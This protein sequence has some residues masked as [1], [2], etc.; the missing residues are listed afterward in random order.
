MGAWGRSRGEGV[1]VVIIIVKIVGVW[2]DKENVGF[3]SV[4]RDDNVEDIVFFIGVN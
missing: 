3:M 4:G 2:V 1:E